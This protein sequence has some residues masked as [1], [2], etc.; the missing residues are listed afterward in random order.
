MIMNE[1]LTDD[2]PN[3][4]AW[5]RELVAVGLIEGEVR[6]KAIQEITAEEVQGR[7]VHYFAGIGG[8]PFALRLAGWPTSRP[9]W[10][11]SCPC[12]PFSEAGKR[13]GE[14]DER[15]LWPVLFRLIRD[16]R[17]PT[18]FGEQ[19]AGRDGFRWLTRV[20]A[21]LEAEGYAVGCADLPAGSV[22]SPQRRQ[23]LFF[24]ANCDGSGL[25]EW[26]KQS[27]RK[28]C[29]T[30]ERS[31]VAGT[32]A[33]ASE[34]R[35]EGSKVGR[36]NRDAKKERGGSRKSE[37]SCIA[38]TVGGTEGIKGR[39]P[40]ERK[41]RSEDVELGRASQACPWSSSQPI[42]CTDG[43][44]RRVP[45]S[46]LQLVADGLPCDL[47]VLRLACDGWPKTAAKIKGRSAILR[48]AGNAI[49]PQV[50]AVFVRAAME[51][52]DNQ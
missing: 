16:C 21:D 22:G 14:A 48:G 30:I 19:V 47:D 46:S 45:E 52:V 42:L 13:K 37:R 33:S 25:Q 2:D 24:V 8:W 36:T 23:R 43:K 39:L 35:F 44:Y 18:L 29:E 49:V 17:P 27:T 31:G 12:Q 11:A 28:E 4:C 9:V 15:H 1:I 7:T 50:A 6:E 26:P 32:V 41:E 38:G 34:S 10:T 3:V 5:L 40:T 51:I 20:R